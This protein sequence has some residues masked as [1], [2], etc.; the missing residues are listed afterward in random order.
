MQALGSAIE[1]HHGPNAGVW[2]ALAW[3]V[4][5]LT[6]WIVVVTVLRNASLGTDC[7]T[8]CLVTEGWLLYT[9]AYAAMSI[10]AVVTA[11][12][13]IVWLLHGH[14]APLRGVAGDSLTNV[15]TEATL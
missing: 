9:V 15:S 12:E 4:P 2:K 6:V 3:V 10:S 14:G 1:R 13:V 8:V 7:S 5:H 11:V